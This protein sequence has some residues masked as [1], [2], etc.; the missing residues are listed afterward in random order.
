M[1][2]G[3][4]VHRYDRYELTLHGPADGNPFRDVWLRATGTLGT[5]QVRLDGFF[6]GDG[7]YRVRL[8]PDAEGVWN[9]VTE[10][11]AVELDGVRREFTCVPPREGVHGPVRVHDTFHFAHDDGT[12][13]F[14]FGTTCYAWIHQP[15][16]LQE[17]TL[18]TLARAPF[19]KLRMTVFPK[20][21][22]YNQNEPDLY[23]FERDDSGENL[24]ERPNPVFC[25]ALEQR[26]GQL[27][28]MGIEA[29]LILFHPYDRWGY[30]RMGMENDLAYLRYVIARLSAYRNIWWSLANEYDFMLAW[31]TVG[32]W[33]AYF[34]AIQ[35]HDSY[36]HLRSIHNGDLNAYYDHTKPWVT[37]VC[38]Q[39]PAVDEA[40]AWRNR[41]GK[42]V[43]DDEC[44]YEGNIPMPWGNITGR[45]L[46]HRFWVMVTNGTYAGH[47]E[48]YMHPEDE[49]WWSKGGDLRGESWQRIGFLKE[50]IA[51][52][53]GPLTPL[54]KE[55]V[56]TRVSAGTCGDYRLI[57]FGS[58]Q[59]VAWGFG[60]PADVTYAVDWIDT[61]NMTITE[62]PGTFRNAREIPLPGQP[63]MATRIRPLQGVG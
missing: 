42:P 23:P 52:G 16:E 55:W 58:H 38:V 19:N 26:V 48:T 43:I 6:D 13:Y 46:V 4:Q 61:W 35:E 47:G 2:P 59:P 30:A 11:N 44:E 45:E 49:L 54:D 1:S 37:H 24:Y 10:S 62:L 41:Y 51:S 31:K 9:V 12:P 39:N 56:W 7:T 14:P 20:A 63:Y 34:Q 21:Y 40:R 25:R 17:R 27:A 28:E 15:Q 57:Y 53:P 50:I 33:D 22:L 29:D 3:I 18:A 36:A 8:M 60:L 5:R 32:H